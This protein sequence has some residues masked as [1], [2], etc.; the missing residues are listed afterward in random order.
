MDETVRE[1]LAQLV[2]EHGRSLCTTPRVVSMMLRNVC[3]DAQQPIHEIELA[4]THGCVAPMLV[5]LPESA[6]VAALTQKLID[7][8]GLNEDRAR[9]AIETWVAALCRERP[10]TSGLKRDW[11]QWNRL[12]VTPATGGPM[13][14]YQRSVIHLIVVA[15]AG[16]F[17]ATTLGW[18]A[19]FK[20]DFFTFSPWSDAVSDLPEWAQ[21]LS[22]IVLGALGGGAGGLLGWIFGGGRSWT[23]DAYG[24]S[25]LGRLWYSASGA[26][27]GANI[28]VLGGLAMI[29][30]MGATL[31]GL[32]GAALGAWMGQLTAERISRFWYW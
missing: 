6:D 5:G 17:G 32:L 3:P 24:A 27:F 30:L 7:A 16:A 19:L 1:Q 20:P 11:S 18:L 28:G 10:E 2:A 8:T 29:G 21:G 26:Y 15:A 9:W 14:T 25:T 31:G 13:G 22:V 12:E 23:Y 4:L